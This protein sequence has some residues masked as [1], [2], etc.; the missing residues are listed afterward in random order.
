MNQINFLS[1]KGVHGIYAIKNLVTGRIYI[2]Q[3]VNTKKRVIGHRSLLRAN[4]HSNSYL[5]NSWNK[6]G[7]ENF[8]FFEVEVVGNEE[9]LTEREQHWIDYHKAH[10]K[11]YGYNLAP[12]EKHGYSRSEIAK[13][14]KQVAI[15]RLRKILSRYT[16]TTLPAVH[17]TCPQEKRDAHW[18]WGKKATKDGR[19]V[20]NA[21]RWYPEL[22]MIATEMGFVGL[23]DLRDDEQ[24]AIARLQE[25]I[26]KYATAHLP[27][28]RSSNKEE[29]ADAWWVSKKK[30]AK[31]GDK[32]WAWFPVLEQMATA[33][34]FV[35]LFDAV[36]D[37]AAAVEKMRQ[38]VARYSPDNPPKT[39][40]LTEQ[41]RMDA[42]FLARRRS[43]KFGKNG[44]F[45][46]PELEEIAFE[47]GFYNLFVEGKMGPRKNTAKD[48]DRLKSIL[49]QFGPKPRA[50]SKDKQE[51]SAAYW[52]RHKRKLKWTNS[53]QWSDELDRV[54][55][56]CGHP[57]LFAKRTA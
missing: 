49:M 29:R 25:I 16:P 57:G 24:N 13:R 41:E 26:G 28:Q 30:R 4:C 5:Q 27:D 8:L 43:A 22:E 35:G 33:A 52:L 42:S 23:F 9:L 14:N 11:K 15:R 56:L 31:Y 6:H 53:S 20:Q 32:N 47:Y 45:W 38:I 10:D 3:A 21:G 54:V 46:Y 18:L 44:C 19:S 40:G 51:A 2:G 36:D 48:V 50:K 12:A 7:E 37:R 55:E 39:N 34:G 17:A 1:Y